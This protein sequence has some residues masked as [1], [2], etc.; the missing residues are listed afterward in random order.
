MSTDQCKTPTATP[1]ARFDKGDVVR[2][3][4]EPGVSVVVLPTY[5][6]Q[7]PEDVPPGVPDLTVCCVP[8]ALVRT[9]T[10]DDEMG[11]LRWVEVGDLRAVAE[12]GP[13]DDCRLLDK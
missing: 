13:G 3:R 6:K 4:R 8:V 12:E 5:C 1:V 11:V 2:V 7:D 10:P 9:P